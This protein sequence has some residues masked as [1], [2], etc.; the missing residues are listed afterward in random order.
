M[1]SIA[2]RPSGQWRARYRDSDGRE[3]AKHFRRKADAQEWLDDQTAALVRGDWVDPKAGKVT[4]RSY[5]GEWQSVQVSSAG[6][7][8]IVD[9]A[10]RLHILPALGDLPVSAIRPTRVQGFVKALEAKGLQPGSVRNVFDVLKRVMTAAVDDQVIRTSPCTAKIALPQRHDDEVQ[11]P[12]VEDVSAAADAIGERWRAMVV[13]LAGTGLR[14]GELLGLDVA[15]V[16]FLR[17]TIRVERQRSQGGEV[18]PLKTKAS[19][20]VVPVGQVVIDELA[21]HLARCPSDGALFV[22]EFGKP[23]L[24][25]RWKQ[26]WTAAFAPE[27]EEDEE[28]ED[29]E[30]DVPFTAHGLR[31]FAASALISGGASVKQV[32]TFLGHSS[33]TVTLRTYAHLWPGDEDRTRDV[34]DA[35]LGPLA[36][37][38]RT[39]S[40]SNC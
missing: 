35:A 37:S 38:L 16:D 2:K 12:S 9:N 20:R 32:Q 40:A 7:A 28:P 36:D 21:A 17:R 6:T 27:V 4:L 5:A 11:I 34:L 26:L 13:T 14:I 10:L 23:L 1:S 3:H 31:H 39:E 18:T 30:V 29:V 8:R 15:D 33:A 25:R 22:D 19:R 24:Y